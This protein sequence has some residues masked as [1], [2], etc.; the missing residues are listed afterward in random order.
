MIQYMN[1][2]D[3]YEHVRVQYR[4]PHSPSLQSELGNSEN[5]SP[6]TGKC[7]AAARVLLATVLVFFCQFSGYT[8]VSFYATAI[9]RM[10]SGDGDTDSSGNFFRF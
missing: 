10:N 5:E 4:I 7:A 6:S 3:Y 9:L 1:E 8:I 2:V